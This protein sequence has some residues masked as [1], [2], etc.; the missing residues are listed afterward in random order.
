MLGRVPRLRTALASRQGQQVIGQATPVAALHQRA[1][2]PTDQRADAKHANHKDDAGKH[3]TEEASAF[4]GGWARCQLRLTG[5]GYLRSVSRSRFGKNTHRGRVVVEVE[6]A[7][8]T[9]SEVADSQRAAAW[10]G[11]RH[12]YLF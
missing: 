1:E 6:L 9:E 12:S 4:L 8:P 3:P 5:D 10:A 11:L 2:D 7:R